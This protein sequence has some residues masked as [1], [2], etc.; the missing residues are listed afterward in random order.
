MFLKFKIVFIRGV[1][2]SFSK[3]I[4]GSISEIYDKTLNHKFIKELSTGD[5][6]VDKFGYYISQ[7]LLYL[8]FYSKVLAIASTK[9]STPEDQRI[10]INQS[11]YAAFGETG[12]HRYYIDTYKLDIPKRMGPSAFSYSHYLLSIALSEPL[13]VTV[14]ALYPCAII[15]AE[16]GLELGR[17]YKKEGNIYSKW[18]EEYSNPAFMESAMS[19]RDILDRSAVD[20]PQAEKDKMKEAFTV[21]AKLEYLFWDDAYNLRSWGI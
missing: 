15:Y 19:V 16:I 13:S 14:A 6:P 5:L 11:I 20:A 17:T 3:L 4:W 21:S 12:M 2:V 7:D 1:I 9:A 18:I 8:D 10:L